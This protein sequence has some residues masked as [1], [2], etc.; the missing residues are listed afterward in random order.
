MKFKILSLILFCCTASLAQGS[1]ADVK[2]A[3]VTFFEGFHAQDS[4]KIKSVV[5]DGMIM[6]TMGR[7][8]EGN[9]RLRDV[10]FARF[11]NS[12]VSIPDSVSFKEVITKYTIKVDGPMANAWTDYQF[13]LGGEMSHCGVNSFQLMNQNGQWRIIYLIDTRRKDDCQ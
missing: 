10:E 13:W 8:K 6:Q 1:E 2:Q 9:T 4:T 3:I 12:I 11:L 7:D 5:A